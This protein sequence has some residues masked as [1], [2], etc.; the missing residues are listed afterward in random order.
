MANGS[1]ESR[2][3]QLSG[4]LASGHPGTLPLDLALVAVA[5]LTIATQAVIEGFHIMFVVLTLAALMLPFRGFVIRL[6]VWMAVSTALLVWAIT[7]L[8]VPVNELTELPIL[9]V[10]L[11]LVFLVARARARATA[12]SEAANAE[13]QE[14]TELERRDLERQLEQAQR[15]ELIGRASAGLSHD[16]RNV[17]TA[18][19]GCA[20]EVEEETVADGTAPL[21]DLQRYCLGEI[22]SATNRG[23][24]ILDQ[25]LCLSR[26]NES[27][28]QVTDLDNSIRQLEP[29]LRRLTRPGVILRLDVPATECLVRIDRVGLSQILMNLVSNAN[30]AIVGNGNITVTARPVVSRSVGDDEPVAV[31]TV[32]DDGR[33]FT[34]DE[35]SRAFDD[36]FTS[37]G[38]GHF[39]LGL[40]T[41]WRI[42]ERNGGSMQIDS[43]PNDVTTISIM[44][45]GPGT[46]DTTADDESD[47]ASSSGVD[48]PAG[49]PVAVTDLAGQLSEL[50]SA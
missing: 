24:A 50:G 8:D 48:R 36:G 40:A 41:V 14:R 25:L 21:S 17:F 37:K 49:P 4:W 46:T 33:G 42:V 26:Q 10:V 3:A 6:G 44:L 30:D 45:T 9:T 27:I 19:K 5:V 43:S 39:G 23:L 11:V 47:T 15:R 12:D 18:I 7:S 38:D 20:A 34:P 35:L 2:G 13:L 29:L 22:E 1:G 31:L 16:L 32:S 28:L